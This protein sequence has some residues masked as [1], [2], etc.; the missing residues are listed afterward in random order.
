LKSWPYRGPVGIR[1][2]STLG[3]TQVH[4]VD[5]WQY[6]GSMTEDEPGVP[7]RTERGFD[8]DAYRI[9]TRYLRPG[10][11]SVRPLENLPP[12]RAAPRH[13]DPADA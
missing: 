5:Q 6:L 9:L 1:E 8:A 4:V 3:L 11:R 13:P 10:L 12:R 7:T 2:T